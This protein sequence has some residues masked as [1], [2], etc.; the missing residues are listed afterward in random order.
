[1]IAY[2][3]LWYSQKLIIIYPT[4]F[5][6]PF[7]NIHNF[8]EDVSKV[9]DNVPSQEFKASKEL[10]TNNLEAREVTNSD[11]NKDNQQLEDRRR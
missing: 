4:I 11:Q 7:G 1:M 8:S 6:F 2:S 3:T 10:E 5:S 9:T